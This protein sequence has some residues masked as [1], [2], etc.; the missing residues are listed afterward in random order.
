MIRCAAKPALD[1]D[2]LGRIPL[3]RLVDYEEQGVLHVHIV[4][5]GAQV[6]QG[7]D[8]GAVQ[9]Q[10]VGVGPHDGLLRQELYLG[11]EL[12]EGLDG[13]PRFGAWVS[14]SDRM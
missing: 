5:D 1:D 2:G 12:M 10:T 13:Q 4:C 7:L 11:D 8:F 6:L 9:D 3:R 14:V